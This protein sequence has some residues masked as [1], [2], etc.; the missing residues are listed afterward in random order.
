MIIIGEKINATIPSIKEAVIARDGEKLRDLAIRQKQ[1]GADIIDVNVG[2]GEGSSDDE[3]GDMEWLVGLLKTDAV[4]AMLCIDS[5]DA[6]VLEAGLR[7][8]GRK[9]AM[10]NSVKAAEES[11]GEVLPLAAEH[12]V[13][14]VALAMDEKGIPKDADGRLK[15]C[16]KILE[17][18]Q[19]YG[20]SSEKIFFD[21]LVFPIS[22]DISQGMTVIETLQK[23]KTLFSGAKTVLALSNVSFGLPKRALINT[24]MLHMA[25]LSGIDAA[26]INP[27]DR[28]VMSAVRAGDAVLGRDRHCRKYMRAMRQDTQKGN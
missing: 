28:A 5:A 13:P 4:D 8:G 7:A 3:C 17:G 15:A 23:I 27:L 21:P 16:G 2:T 26:I 20:V 24:A 11:M 19:S 25:M 18:A 22:T 9:V 1:A 14:V 6:A 10:I 12:G